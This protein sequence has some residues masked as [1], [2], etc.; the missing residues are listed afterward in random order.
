MTNYF[1]EIATDTEGKFEALLK[2]PWDFHHYSPNHSPASRFAVNLVLTETEIEQARKDGYDVQ[3]IHDHDEYN[4]KLFK[5]VSQGKIQAMIDEQGDK[6]NPETVNNYWEVHEIE[7]FMRNMAEDSLYKDIVTIHQFPLPTSGPDRERITYKYV[8]LGLSSSRPKPA[9][10]FVGGMHAREW[11]PPEV[12]VQFIYRLATCYKKKTGV[13]LPGPGGGY[14]LTKD[15]LERIVRTLDIYVIP[16]ANPEG[17]R[18]GMSRP[19]NADWR[20][21]RH[22]FTSSVFG[23]DL[24]RNFDF[25]WSSGFGQSTTPNPDPQQ[26]YRGEKPGSENEVKN[27]VGLL[28]SN[29]NIKFFV[30]IHSAGERVLHPW[31]HD[32]T[33]TD[34]NKKDSAF[35]NNKFDGQRHTVGGYREYTP[36]SDL[37]NL[38]LLAG[39]MRAA[40]VR[41]NNNPYRDMA[42]WDAGT[43]YRMAGA[44]DDYSFSR[45]L[46]NTDKKP[47]INA[48]TIECAKTF[49][50][51]HD[52]AAKVIDETNAGM[53]E[54]CRVASVGL[55]DEESGEFELAD[56]DKRL[57]LEKEPVHAV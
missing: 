29:P 15:L 17:T 7:R 11:I 47:L 56:E 55:Y 39:L 8:K 51:S 34:P 16:N 49:R 41:V 30:D 21:N 57:A 23:V 6:F 3:I 26:L 31:S 36:Q 52:I 44:S 27:I 28:D 24:N 20:K 18:F 10:V 2:H 48:F 54:L 32:E 19:E 22:Q 43:I 1:V 12:C 46:R 50:P 37:D 42:S 13:N 14:T 25:L 40:I 38:K 35:W 4:E 53:F 33:T 5:E 45:H 9:I